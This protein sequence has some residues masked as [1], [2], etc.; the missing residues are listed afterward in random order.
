MF[1]FVV[2]KII[3]KN[4]RRLPWYH[5]FSIIIS[6]QTVLI[7]ITF[8]LGAFW[9]LYSFQTSSIA[10]SQF[11][12]SEAL[13]ISPYSIRTWLYSIFERMVMFLPTTLLIK[14]C[15]LLH[16]LTSFSH[17]HFST[18]NFLG[19]YFIYFSVDVYIPTLTSKIICSL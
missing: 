17:F 14:V 6:N 18:I 5:K 8:L 7:F 10:S 13:I 9:W 1:P 15:N 3:F 11:E 2:H 16:L 12:I 19:I 4:S